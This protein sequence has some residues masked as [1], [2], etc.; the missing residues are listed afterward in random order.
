MCALH[1]PRWVFCAQAG[2]K[3][4]FKEYPTPAEF[5]GRNFSALSHALQ[6]DWMQVQEFGGLLQVEG[7][8]GAIS[9]LSNESD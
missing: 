5:G 6:G 9:V 1:H 4:N 8:H 7:V 2:N 3:V